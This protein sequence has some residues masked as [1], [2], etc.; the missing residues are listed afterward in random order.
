MIYVKEIDLT[1]NFEAPGSL[2]CTRRLLIL[3]E[4]VM[5][6]LPLIS[7]CSKKPFQ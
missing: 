3:S 7:S 2:F 6:I 1:K 5:Y 4:K